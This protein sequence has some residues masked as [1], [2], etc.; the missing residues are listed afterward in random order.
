MRPPHSAA[1]P[2]LST[3]HPRHADTLRHDPH[4]LAASATRAVRDGY[5]LQP[6]PASA[7]GCFPV[8][9]I[10]DMNRVRGHPSTQ[11][12]VALTTAQHRHVDRFRSQVS[13][14]S[15]ALQEHQPVEPLPANARLFSAAR[16][17]CGC[18]ANPQ[19]GQPAV[20]HVRNILRL[21][22]MCEAKFSGLPDRASSATADGPPVDG[23]KG[24]RDSES[25]RQTGGPAE[26]RPA[27]SFL[28]TT[29]PDVKS[30][31]TRSARSR[32]PCR[33]RLHVVAAGGHDR[34]P[35]LPPD[36]R[37]QHST[38]ALQKDEFG[39]HRTLVARIRGLS[40]PPQPGRLSGKTSQGERE[41]DRHCLSRAWPIE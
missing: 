2:I 15:H 40:T 12:L 28:R 19:A 35:C 13:A 34:I 9:S 33:D 29:Q 3:S 7:A 21:K 23:K 36:W 14:R 18:A 38:R 17:S 39:R 26:I 41:V 10:P 32:Q 1:P 16:P 27:I 4:M 5:F 8:P 31:R 25:E 24:R 22:I 30:R 6:I 20:A 37:R 11:P